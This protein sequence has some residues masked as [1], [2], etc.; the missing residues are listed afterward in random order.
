MNIA[1]FNN[2]SI[3]DGPGIRF[4]VYTQG[5]KHRCKGCHNPKTWSTR[6]NEEYSVT[7]IV[8]LI[9]EESLVKNVTI[10]GGDPLL[11]IEECYELCSRLKQLGYNIWLYTGYTLN[12]IEASDDLNR[13]LSV[14]DVLV[15]GKFIE[16]KFNHLLEY[17]GSS[18]QNII[19]LN[20]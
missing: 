13:I 20:E 18:N 19:Y 2:S 10:S 3:V 5:C 14:I 4:T 12:E 9:E 11:Q 16:D 1:G 17:R 6:V 7:H 8:N 15:D